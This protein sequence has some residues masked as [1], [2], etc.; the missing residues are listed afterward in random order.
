MTKATRTNVFILLDRSGSMYARWEE[1]LGSVN[2]YIHT[3]RDDK[4]LAKTTIAVFDDHGYDVLR[5]AVNPSKWKDITDKEVHPRGM[6][7]LHDSVIKMCATI[8]KVKSRKNVLV[9]YT[10]GHE[11][12]SKDGSKAVA[13]AAVKRLEDRGFE[14]IFLGADFD[15]MRDAASIGRGFEKTLNMTQG[16]FGATMSGLA[17][18]TAL[19]A[20]DVSGGIQF[21]TADRA[22]AV[23]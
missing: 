6:T 15:A 19:Y 12:A 13:K 8:E 10:D 9:I 18:S 3:L 2:T 17:K 21:S 4:A 14:I 20:S 22:A 1:V 16:N 5:D 11:N 7:P 23:K